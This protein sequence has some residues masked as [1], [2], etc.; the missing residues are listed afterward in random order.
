MLEHEGKII[1]PF[2][3]IPLYADKE[4]NIVNMIVEIPRWSN[5]KFEVMNIFV[6][7]VKI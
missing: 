1:S 6:R 7:N 3:D 2:H 4:K 5:A